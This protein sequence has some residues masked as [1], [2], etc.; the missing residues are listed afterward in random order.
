MPISYQTRAGEGTGYGNPFVGPV[1]H[2]D[3]VAVDLSG[4]TDDEVDAH[5]YIKPGVPLTVD[6]AL[7]AAEGAV[8]GVTIEAIKVAAGNA[9]ADLTGTVD[10]ALG[11]IGQVNQAV[12]EDNLGRAYTAAEVAGFA[13]SGLIL[14]SKEG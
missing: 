8:H 6:G 2:T 9:S 12:A 7:V 4:L 14:L 1:N 5:G 3:A 11:T 10:I 13:G